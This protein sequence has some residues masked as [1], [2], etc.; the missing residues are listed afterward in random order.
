[1]NI[2]VNGESYFSPT[3]MVSAATPAD[4][5]A[6]SMA[7]F[8]ADMTTGDTGCGCSPT[9]SSDMAMNCR[10]TGQGCNNPGLQQDSV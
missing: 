6:N 9:C 4:T 3:F 7:T 10:F 2:N 8:T 1:M 5:N